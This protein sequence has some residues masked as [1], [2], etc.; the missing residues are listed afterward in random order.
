M[1]APMIR[2]ASN[3]SRSMMTNDWTNRLDGAHRPTTVCSARARLARRFGRQPPAPPAS[4]PAVRVRSA[5]KSASSSSGQRG[6]LGAN[7]TLD[8][9]ERHVSVERARGGGGIAGARR[10]VRTES[11]CALT[12]AKTSAVADSAALRLDGRT[13]ASR[14]RSCGAERGEHLDV[15]HAAG[16][17]KGGERRRRLPRGGR[18]PQQRGVQC[19]GPTVLRRQ[20]VLEGRHGRRRPRRC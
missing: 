12:W 4:P 14:D 6:V 3:P 1:S 16:S 18:K 9:L 20:P 17:G 19:H 5:A 13:L 15:R 11:T 8:L 7:R 2:I 10:G